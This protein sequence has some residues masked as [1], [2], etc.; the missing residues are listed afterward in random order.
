MELGRRRNSKLAEGL[1]GGD[2]GHEDFHSRLCIFSRPSLQSCV[3]A[4]GRQRRQYEEKGRVCGSVKVA[5][6]PGLFL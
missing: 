3:V 1:S 5:F 6:V 2:D 4:K